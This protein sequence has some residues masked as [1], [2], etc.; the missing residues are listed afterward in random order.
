MNTSDSLRKGRGAYALWRWAE[1][2]TH[3]S[4]ADLVA[5][6]G[7]DD[8]ERLATA[9]FLTGRDE[10]YGELWV[11]AHQECLRVGNVV[12]AAR[13]A[14]WIVLDLLIKGELA[15]AG[16]WLARAR[17]LLDDARDDCPEYGLLLVL[18]AR[19]AL[20][21]GQADAAIE[22]ARRA[23]ASADRF[24]DPELHV[25]SLLIGA[26]V[27][28][29]VGDA[30]EAGALFDEAMVAV[31][32][33]D[34]SPIAVGVVYC[35]VI[36]SCR[37]LFDVRRAREWT[38]ALAQWCA[39]E[40]ELVPFRGQCLVHRVEVIRLSGAWAEAIAEAERA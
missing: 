10:V 15:R 37:Q 20:Q 12:R 11:R 24:D 5:P 1:A 33:G 28:A 22:N 36:S 4:A 32:I 35:A 27:R 14:F 38:A 13:F 18:Q 39:R 25:F 19:L 2:Y 3:L 30:R 17:H 40:P 21:Q 29:E 34:A 9:A 7:I 8:A 16:G 23:V 31:T 6:L 26:Q